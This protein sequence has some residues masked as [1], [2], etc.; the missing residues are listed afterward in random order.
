ME[1]NTNNVIVQQALAKMVAL[2]T[3]ELARLLTEKQV[4]LTVLI[5]KG[6]LTMLLAKVLAAT[7]ED[8]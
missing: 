2:E 4:H 5:P 7:E 8:H 1:C 6:I 3:L